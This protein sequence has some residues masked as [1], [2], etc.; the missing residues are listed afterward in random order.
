MSYKNFIA[1][2]LIIRNR[3]KSGLDDYYYS[4][5]KGKEASDAALTL[6]RHLTDPFS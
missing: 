2:V 6:L 1:V 4:Y 3:G 5:C